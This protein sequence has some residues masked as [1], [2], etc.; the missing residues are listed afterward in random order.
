MESIHLEATV[1]S[2][3]VT[4]DYENGL[5]ELDGK[6]Y[7]E[8][9]FEFYEPIMAW[10]E[11]YFSG[12]AKEQ[13]T[14]NIKFTYFNSATSQIV[15]DFF[16]VISEGEAEN[17][18]VNWYYDASKKSGLKDYEDYAEEFEDLKIQAIEF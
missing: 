11:S 10:V 13:T 15:F 17:L 14:I 2:P 6:S 16:D 9:T 3:K 18:T 5:I 7:P 12:K 4:L 1:N 8:N